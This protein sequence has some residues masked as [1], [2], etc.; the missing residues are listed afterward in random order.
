MLS[1]LETLTSMTPIPH[2][3]TKAL[4]ESKNEKKR[5]EETKVVQEVT[6]SRDEQGRSD[7]QVLR[8]PQEKQ[9][10]PSNTET[11]KH[12]ERNRGAGILCI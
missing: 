2:N 3:M 4:R 7:I 1:V 5:N 12:T 8:C 6:K 10:K 9:K 11:S